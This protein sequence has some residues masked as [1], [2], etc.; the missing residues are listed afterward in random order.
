VVTT[1]IGVPTVPNAKVLGEILGD[2]AKKVLVFKR[3]GTKATAASVVIGSIKQLE[4]HGHR[5]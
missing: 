1:E 2:K 5:R 3:N 4:D